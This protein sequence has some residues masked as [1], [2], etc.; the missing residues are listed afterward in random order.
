MKVAVNTVWA[1]VQTSD[2]SVQYLKQLQNAN[3][4]YLGYRRNRE[5]KHTYIHCVP[6]KV[7]PP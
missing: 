3:L 1:T 7:P 6:K 2:V 4:Y 5:L